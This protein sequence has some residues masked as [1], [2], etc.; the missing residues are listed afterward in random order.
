MLRLTRCRLSVLSVTTFLLTL[1]AQTGTESNFLGKWKLNTAKS[2]YKGV[3]TP[4]E[5]RLVV[6]KATDARFKWHLA[7]AYVEK[8]RSVWKDYGFDGPIDGK[9]HDY[10]GAVPGTKLSYVDDNGSLVGTSTYPNGEIQHDTIT[11]SVDGNTMTSQSTYSSGGN[12]LSWTEVWERE[13]D[14]KHK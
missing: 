10:Q 14:K 7:I 3:P 2:Q 5:A 1:S 8:G 11:V 13:P 12:T 6:S 4:D 9:P